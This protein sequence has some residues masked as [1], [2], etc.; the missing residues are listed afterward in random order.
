MQKQWEVLGTRLINGIVWRDQ[1]QQHRFCFERWIYQCN[2]HRAQ[3]T[4]HKTILFN[5]SYTHVP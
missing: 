2:C 5:P 3:Y 4:F 1:H